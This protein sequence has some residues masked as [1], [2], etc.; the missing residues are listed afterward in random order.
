MRVAQGEGRGGEGLAALQ[1]VLR[2]VLVDACE[3]VVVV[4]IVGD[5]L[6][7]V[8]ARIADGSTDDGSRVLLSL[9]VERE[10]H[11][12]MIGMRVACAVLVDNHL[13][14]GSQRFLH[15]LGLVGP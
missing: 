7:A 2:V 1:V 15:Q 13:L 12:A 9:A 4:G 11:L 6:Q 10:H 5:H 3:E 14:A 8:V